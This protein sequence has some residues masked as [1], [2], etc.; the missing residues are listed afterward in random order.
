MRSSA[1]IVFVALAIELTMRGDG[2]N[3]AVPQLEAAL[4]GPFQRM[5]QVNGRERHVFLLAVRIVIKPG[6]LKTKDLPSSHEAELTTET[7]RKN[8]RYGINKLPT[9]KSKLQTTYN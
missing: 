1:T 2:L 3:E 7:R 6:Q 9:T 5:P 4:A 8:N